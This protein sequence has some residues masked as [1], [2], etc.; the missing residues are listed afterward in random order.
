MSRIQS[1]LEQT[2]L[3]LEAIWDRIGLDKTTRESKLSD[4]IECLN[5]HMTKTIEVENQ[6]KQN[7]ESTVEKLYQSIKENSQFIG[8]TTNIDEVY[9]HMVSKGHDLISMQNAL[10]DQLEMINKVITVNI[11]ELRISD[12]FNRKRQKRSYCLNLS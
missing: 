4:L 2:A 11:L 8:I 1:C 5:S 10:E 3:E 12:T 6:R 7:Y 9:N